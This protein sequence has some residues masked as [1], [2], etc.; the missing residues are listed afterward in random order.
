M[1]VAQNALVQTYCLVCHT[2]THRNGGLSLEH[3]D[4]AHPDPGVAA[5][6]LSKLKTGAIGAAGVK[7]PDDGTV[8]AWLSAMS[9]E[10]AGAD[11]WRVNRTEDPTTKASIL[12]VTIVQEVP[13]ENADLPDS[14]RLTVTCR[15]DTHEAAM[16]LAW[17]PGFRKTGQVLSAFVDGEAL[18]TYQVE[19]T[20]KMGNGA[21]GSSGPGS[22][23][24]YTN[25]MN[26]GTAKLAIVL[27]AHTLMIR[28]AFPN[29]TVVFP[30][31]ELKQ[32]E[33][34]AFS[35]CFTGTIASR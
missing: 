6:M 4:A 28:D 14:Y 8:H 27:P 18:S 29:E 15:A 34:Q 9:A 20:E 21:D 30:F 2:D 33:R 31:G 24:L 22:I 5:M 17:A 16:E 11:R 1:P 35:T 25:Q 19:G 7:P 32:T 12:S 3:F 13:S 26:S 23:L 10:A